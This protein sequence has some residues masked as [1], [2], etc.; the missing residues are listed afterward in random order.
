MK[1][2]QAT[3]TDLIEFDFGIDKYRTRVV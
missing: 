3:V 1:Q 2:K